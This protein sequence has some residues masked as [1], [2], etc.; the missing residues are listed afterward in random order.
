MSSI[1]QQ[2]VGRRQF[3]VASSTCALATAVVGPSLFAGAAAS[4][5]KRL[6][7]GFALADENAAL[8]AASNVPASDGGFISRGA[9]VTVSGASGAPAVPSQRR[10]VELLTHYSY[11]DGGERRNAPFRAWGSSRKT[12]SQGN[13]VSF[14]VPVD[15]VQSIR[16]SVG[17]ESGSTPAGAPTT[18]R[19]AVGGVAVESHA[20]PVTL[21]LLSDRDSLKL[22]R[23]FYVIVPLFEQDSEPR[24]SQWQVRRVE[25]RMA[26]VDASNNPAQFEHFVLRIDYAS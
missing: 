9:R 4:L 18:R 10:G 21:S 8:N 11:L 23:G 17:I 26:L 15:D 6:A 1:S 16:F 5:P 22:V 13:S 19:R 7:V 14:N 12:G 2:K 25:G 20:L 24:W 3:L